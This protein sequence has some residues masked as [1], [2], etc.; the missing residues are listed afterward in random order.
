MTPEVSVLPVADPTVLASLAANAPWLTG[1]T[2]AGSLFSGP[3]EVWTATQHGRVGALVRF[4]PAI[5]LQAPR[6]WYHVGCVVHASPELGR[7][8]P[9][10]T[11]QLNNDL[12]G[13][14]EIGR[15][16]V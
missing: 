2:A 5:G 1:H 11:L 8:L 10:A 16:H 3:G 15:A 13:E 14:A 9:L 4:T 12:T 6:H 7:R